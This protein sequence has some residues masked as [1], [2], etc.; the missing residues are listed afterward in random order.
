MTDGRPKALEEIKSLYPTHPGSAPF[1]ELERQLEQDRSSIWAEAKREIK[2][3]AIRKL[4]MLDEVHRDLIR[5][6]NAILDQAKKDIFLHELPMNSAKIRG[7]TYFLYQESE[8][9][10][11]KFFSILEPHEYVKAD[12]VA[13]FLGSYRLNEDSTWTLL[14]DASS[15][16]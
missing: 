9:S 10:V 6:A 13:V 14:S 5:K 16:E 2:T 1:R 4:E 11:S 3:Q 8:N 7:Q 15:S 12:P